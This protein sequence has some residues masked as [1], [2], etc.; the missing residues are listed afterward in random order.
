MSSSSEIFSK[1][2]SITATS[3]L[4][5]YR[6]RANFQTSIHLANFSGLSLYEI[7]STHSSIVWPPLMTKSSLHF[8]ENIWWHLKSK[9]HFPFLI[10]SISIPQYMRVALVRKRLQENK[11][12]CKSSSWIIELF[13]GREMQVEIIS[14]AS[15]MHKFIAPLPNKQTNTHT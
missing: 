13:S 14:A 10:F 4:K 2:I 15:I 11:C 1:I 9:C 6:K 8:S 5:T 7:A 12:K 3:C